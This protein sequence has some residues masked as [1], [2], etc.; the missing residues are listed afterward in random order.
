[1]VN[2]TSVQVFLFLLF[3]WPKTVII[4]SVAFCIASLF[5]ITPLLII[6]QAAFKLVI[7]TS[8]VVEFLVGAMS[9]YRVR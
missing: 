5:N 2:Q 4:T 8:I 6:I 1:M 9:G 7:I 3:F